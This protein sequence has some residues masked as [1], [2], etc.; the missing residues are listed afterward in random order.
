MHMNIGA[1]FSVIDIARGV[2]KRTKGRGKEKRR[3]YVEES[4]WRNKTIDVFTLKRK[5]ASR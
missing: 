3:I 2:Q 4:Q 5:G 1:A